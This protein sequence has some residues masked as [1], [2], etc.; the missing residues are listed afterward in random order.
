MKADRWLQVE[1][2]YHEARELE[3]GERDRFLQHACADQALRAEVESLLKCEGQ[4]KDYL[5]TPAIEVT[6]EALAEG[7]SRS[8]LDRVLGPYQITAFLDSGGMGEVYRARDSRI[9]RDVAIKVLP[10]A[11]AADPERLRLFEQEARAAGAINHPNILTIH[12]VGV[13]DGAPYVVY[14]L[15]EGA[16]LRQILRKKTPSWRKALEY[17]RQIASGLAAAHVRGIVHSDL[18]PENLFVTH[19]GRV[20]ILDFGIAKL[21]TPDCWSGG[22]GAASSQNG[23]AVVLGTPGYMSPEQ[24]GGGVVDGRTDLFSLGAILFEMLTGEQPFQGRSTAEKRNAILNDDPVDINEARNKI[25][26][27]LARLVFRCLEKDPAERIQSA[28]DLSFDLQAFLVRYPEPRPPRWRKRT[29]V[30]GLAAAVLS[31]ALFFAV[32]NLERVW[33]HPGP[34]FHRLTYRAGVITAARF[35]PDRQSVIYSAAWDGRP[36]EIFSTRIGGPE[37]RPLGLRA[38]G[39]LAVSSAGELALSL[40]CELNWAECRGTLARVPVAGG[41][42]HELIEDVF[43]ADWSHDGKNLVVVRQVDGRFRLEY[44]IGRVLYETTGWITYARLSP[45]GDRIA[46]LDHPTLGEDDGS[47]SVVDLGGHKATLSQGWRNLKGL[48]WSPKGNE[49]WFSADRL[50]RS[51]NLYAVTLS[52]KDRLVLQAPGWMR[53]QEIS[54]DGRVLLLQT[55]P[56]SRIMYQSPDASMQRNL[57]WFDWSTAV[58]LSPDGKKLLFYEW[59]EGVA[60]NPTVY[61][62]D[63]DGSDAIRLG[64]G[65]AL[66]LSPD[67]AFALALRGAPK[68]ILVLLPT[69]PGEEKTLA[70]SDLKQ[71]YSAAWFPDGK[72][73][74]LV[75]AGSDGQ[76]HTYIQDVA[77]GTARAIGDENLL[78]TLVSPDGKLLAGISSTDGYVL[79][80]VGGGDNQPIRGMFPED[81]LIQW[82]ADGRFLYVR[83]QGDTS[84]EFFRVNLANG[85]RER[86][87]SIEPADP[88]GLIGIQSAAMHITPDGKSYAYSYWKTLTE[89]YLVDNLR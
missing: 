27:A 56:R 18:K 39:V 83:G 42:P 49:V 6:A 57:S 40:G 62:R 69:G 3:G 31:L 67:G 53:L 73:I 70:T 2:L 85:R 46:F 84:L 89:L 11:M 55:S 72:R 1:Q 34:R 10:A 75:A 82:S 68:P 51:Q 12:D 28:L 26:P 30:I 36:V 50:T 65:R 5:E 79:Y 52:G 41:A 19:D 13:Q 7:R 17:A 59:G 54:P 76:P 74:L 4:A 86:W 20:K 60:G 71:Y 78:A 45:K 81:D 21:T 77:G 64:E 38:A 29:I 9:G 15:L 22:T 8:M 87:K 44:P 47:V 25:D 48:A 32:A 35:A 58:D 37:S 43:Y 16:T 88:V 61:L 14:E 66:A 63:T 80:P 24:L 33:S 23:S